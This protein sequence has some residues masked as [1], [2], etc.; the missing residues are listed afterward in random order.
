MGEIMD[1]E[2]LRARF[3]ADADHVLGLWQRTAAG[4]NSFLGRSDCTV[5]WECEEVKI[6]FHDVYEAPLIHLLSEGEHPTDGHDFLFLVINSISNRY[7]TFVRTLSEYEADGDANSMDNLL[8]PKFVVKG[9]Y[10]AVALHNS[11]VLS[12][13]ELNL[14]VQSSWNS[15]LQI[16]EWHIIDEALRQVRIMNWQQVVVASL[17]LREL[18]FAFRFPL[19]RTSNLSFTSNDQY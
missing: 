7:A 1:E 9:S 5:L 8:H 14:L 18:T 13:R 19:W 4:L 10:G 12:D 3:D 11:V 2:R 17:V 16:Y 15:E 6:P